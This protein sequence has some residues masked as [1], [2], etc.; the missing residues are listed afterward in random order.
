MY[1]DG[2]NNDSCNERDPT[3]ITTPKLTGAA[4]SAPQSEELMQ[5]VAERIANN[6][7]S[8]KHACEVLGFNLNV[9]KEYKGSNSS[10]Y[11]RLK[12]QVR[13]LKNKKSG[14]SW[15]NGMSVW[16]RS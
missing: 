2:D 7:E 12:T 6:G 14:S 8:Y 3:L 13:K 16:S 9:N 1:H 10:E 15:R 11:S 4:R 5:K